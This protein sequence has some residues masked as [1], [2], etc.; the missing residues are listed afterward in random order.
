ML[1]GGG[2]W[3]SHGLSSIGITDAID[4]SDANIK[5]VALGA[6]DSWVALFDDGSVEYDL[7]GNYGSL[8]NKLRDASDGDIKVRFSPRPYFLRYCE[9]IK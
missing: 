6:D 9:R 1:T 3:R 5:N 2:G 7:Q 8:E 4:A